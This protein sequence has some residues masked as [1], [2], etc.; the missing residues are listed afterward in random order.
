MSRSTT[1]KAPQG[2]TSAQRAAL[3]FVRVPALFSM[4]LVMLAYWR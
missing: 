2:E 3:Y 1:R 4:R